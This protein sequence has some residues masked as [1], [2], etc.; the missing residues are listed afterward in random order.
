MGKVGRDDMEKAFRARLR[1][2]LVICR[3]WGYWILSKE[4]YGEWTGKSIWEAVT[5][6]QANDTA[7]SKVEK[8]GR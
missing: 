5:T 7:C 2:A 6:T 4:G 1:F 8:V 3:W